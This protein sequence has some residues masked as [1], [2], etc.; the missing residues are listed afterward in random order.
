MDLNLINGE[1]RAV[2]PAIIAYL[3]GKGA[4]PAA[5]YG[6]LLA[7]LTATVAAVWSITSKRPSASPP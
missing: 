1:I 5:D 4:I 6:P 2:V 7:G 3:V